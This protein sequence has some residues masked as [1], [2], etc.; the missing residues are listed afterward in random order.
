[1]HWIIQFII[2]RR[3]F[4]SLLFTATVSLWMISS[5][6]QIQAS[7]ARILTMS[8]FYPFQL[9][10]SQTAHIKNIFSENRALRQQLAETNTRL[11]LIED[12]E[13]ENWR[14]RELLDFSTEF[15]HDLVPVRVIA[16]DPSPL[17][18][19][20]VVNAG[21]EHGVVKYMPLVNDHGVVG[22]VVELTKNMSLVQLVK[23]PSSRLSVMDRR[24]RAVGILETE[25]GRDFFVRYRSHEEVQGGDTIITSGLG[26]IFPKGLMVGFVTKTANTE[27]PLFNKVYIDPIVRFE[28]LEE[29]F[30]MKLHPQWAA[31][32]TELDSLKTYDD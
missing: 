32:R 5:S 17:Y 29:L 27:N 8:L 19:S 9:T 1:M 13:K 11:A 6:P 26:G 4:C 28:H 10:L 21:S 24:T 18:R 22:K 15:D 31:F 23:D 3:N 16:R 25:N 14:L 12:Q 7:T 30:I 20:I 2:V